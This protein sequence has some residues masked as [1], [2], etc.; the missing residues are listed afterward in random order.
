MA[1]LRT[2]PA[3]DRAPSSSPTAVT[4]MVLPAPVSPVTTLSPGPSGSVASV[5]TPRSRILS[6]SSMVHFFSRRIGFW[7]GFVRPE[8]PRA[9]PWAGACAQSAPDRYGSPRTAAQG[10][11]SHGWEVRTCGPAAPRTASGACGP[12]GQGWRTCVT[13]TRA[14]GGRSTDRLP[15]HHSTPRASVR[16]STSTASRDRGETTSGLAKRACAL[17]GTIR[18]ASTSGHTTG[19]P[20]E[21]A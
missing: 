20:A 6:S 16:L 1:P 14:P 10:R 15:S 19:P 4:T 8:G 13:S 21:N 12:G 2:A 3:S 18:R 5:M 7:T 11:A 9:A 17:M